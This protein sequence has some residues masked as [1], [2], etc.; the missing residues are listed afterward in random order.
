MDAPGSFDQNVF[1]NCP[2]DP[3]Y[4]PLLQPLLFTLV[5]LGFTPRIAVERAD[6]AELRLDKISGLVRQCRF[7]IHDLSRIR[8]ARKGEFYRMNMPFEFGIDYG[9][10][11]YGPG[12]LRTKRCLVLSTR[13]FEYAKAV[14]DLSGI[15][16]RYHYG[17]PLELVR[18][19]RNWF[20]ETA[21]GHRLPSASVVWYRFSDFIR[22][23][24]R[25]G[26]RKAFRPTI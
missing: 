19:V 11:L 8:A 21:D 7:G 18:Q 5:F 6:S 4:L 26:S 13:P 3:S 20:V 14:S 16:A 9:C 23:S 24:T 25:R 15:D 10:R 12:R 2:F 22:T 17:Q 1:I